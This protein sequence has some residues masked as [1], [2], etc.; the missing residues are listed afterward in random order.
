MSYCDKCGRLAHD[1]NTVYMDGKSYC[2]PCTHNTPVV[3]RPNCKRC[4]HVMIDGD[5]LFR[6]VDMDGESYC[7]LC[8]HCVRSYRRWLADELPDVPPVPIPKPSPVLDQAFRFFGGLHY[9]DFDVATQRA[10]LA[11]LSEMRKAL[12]PPVSTKQLESAME[13]AFDEQFQKTFPW[14]YSWAYGPDGNKEGPK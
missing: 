5:P 10:A 2:M 13:K 9:G 7:M 14:A 11:M 4:G 8:P 1:V 3:Q 12:R 6:I